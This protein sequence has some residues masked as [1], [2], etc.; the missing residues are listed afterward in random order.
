MRKFNMSL[1]KFFDPSRLSVIFLVPIAAAAAGDGCSSTP[2][3][4]P[5]TAE[6]TLELVSGNTFQIPNEERYAYADESGSLRG[7]NLSSG[8][9]NGKWRVDEQGQLCALWNNVDD[10]AE[11]CGVLAAVDEE[12]VVWQE[13]TM[14]ILDGNPKEL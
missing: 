3:P 12:L 7:S 4:G 5:L 2:E 8:G 1:R 9:V 14:N 6:Q 11:R 13:V 10:G